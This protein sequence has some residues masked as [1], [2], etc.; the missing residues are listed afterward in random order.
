MEWILF[1]VLAVLAAMGFNLIHTRVWGNARFMARQ[2]K[3]SGKTLYAFNTA[4]TAAV[5]FVTIIV[6]AALMKAAGERAAIPT[7]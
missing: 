2:A 1:G 3:Y 6:A 5:I 7:A 4:A